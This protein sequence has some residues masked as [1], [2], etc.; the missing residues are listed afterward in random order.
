[1]HQRTQMN[2]SDLPVRTASGLVMAAAAIAVAWVGGIAFDAFW[3]VAAAIVFWEWC[4]MIWSAPRRTLWILLGL[5]Y[6]IVLVGAPVVLRSDGEFGFGAIIFI[7]AVV[8]ATDIFGYVVGRVARGPKLCPAISPQKTWSGAIGGTVGAIV[9]GGIVGSLNGV[10]LVPAAFLA[11][12]L[13]VAAQA[14][15]LL[16][17]AVKRKFGVK[18]S[19][20][21]IPGHGG[22]MDRLDGFIVASLL[23]AAIG[24]LRGD[25]AHAGRGLLAW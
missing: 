19:S 5:A 10:A 1:M 2:S 18:D 9:G 17:S 3:S 6:A 21:I 22:L 11:V 24:V 12:A 14:G 4:T 25:L 20:H 8:W 7:F 15:D 16:E 13:S 23:A